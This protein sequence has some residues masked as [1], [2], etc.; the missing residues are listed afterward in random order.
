[1]LLLDNAFIHSSLIEKAKF[2]SIHLN[3]R[4]LTLYIPELAL[5]ELAFQAIKTKLKKLRIGQKIFSKIK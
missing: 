5:I 2:S 3:L 4:L 1:M